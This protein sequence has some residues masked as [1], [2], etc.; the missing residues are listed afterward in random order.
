MSRIMCRLP[1]EYWKNIDEDRDGFFESVATALTTR[2]LSILTGSG[3]SIA[4]NGPSMGE[5]WD[6][7]AK[8]PDFE[9][10]LD[11]V[12]FS[13]EDRERKNIELLLTKCSFFTGLQQHG[14]EK[15]ET[16]QK[17]SEHAIAKKCRRFITDRNQ[18]EP[19]RNLLHR[20]CYR[21]T[22][23]PRTKI[24]TTNYDL[25]IETAASRSALP[26]LDGFSFAQPRTFHSRYLDC[27]IV[28]R[29]H[30][31]ST[32]FDFLEGVFQLIKLHGSVDWSLKNNGK[33]IRD[34]KTTKPFLIYPRDQKYAA[35]YEQPFLDMIG[36]Y[37]MSLRKPDTALLVIGFGFN[38]H[39]LV[40]PIRSALQSNPNSFKLVICDRSPTRK[41]EQ[42]DKYPVWK[43]LQ[44]FQDAGADITFV[45][46]DF[47][48]FTQALPNFSEAREADDLITRIGRVIEQQRQF[49]DEE[50]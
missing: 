6:E 36:H 19:Y 45:E 49:E 20:V 5:L 50:A 41:I 29:H 35:S 26:Y 4:V 43:E 16:F 32:E 44:A 33:I 25:G 42:E 30:S 9:F 2:N 14:Y 46:A 8:L 17:K 31:E 1:G 39:H 12:N 13:A 10:T 47:L 21:R 40:Q 3:A 28:S 24:Y 23:W 18:L 37:Q 38:D 22:D 48:E 34:E 27:D 7:C 15:V 11:A